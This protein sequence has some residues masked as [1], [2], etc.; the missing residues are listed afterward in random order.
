MINAVDQATLVDVMDEYQVWIRVG[1]GQQYVHGLEPWP[2]PGGTPGFD[3]L[4]HAQALGW[5]ADG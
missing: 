1:G 5:P 2:L 4:A 3:E